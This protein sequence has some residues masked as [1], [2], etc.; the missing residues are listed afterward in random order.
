M[1]DRTPEVRRFQV[2]FEGRR[3]SYSAYVP[4]LPGCAATGRTTRV[5]E[6][7]IAQAVSLHVSELLR[8]GEPLPRATPARRSDRCG[9]VRIDPPAVRFESE[10]R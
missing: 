2:I 5:V 6:R 7:R 1:R 9:A 3:G 10:R 4:D 8:S